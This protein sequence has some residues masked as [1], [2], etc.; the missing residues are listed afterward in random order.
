MHDG[1]WRVQALKRETR[2]RQLKMM[3]RQ[4]DYLETRNRRPVAWGR[5]M[6]AAGTEP[7]SRSKSDIEALNEFV[8]SLPLALLPVDTASLRVRLGN[9]F[10]CKAV[11][12]GSVIYAPGR[13]VGKYIYVI[14][15]GTVAL[16]GMPRAS[17]RSSKS[18]MEM[19][20]DKML[21]GDASERGESEG[22]IHKIGAGSIFGVAGRPAI[23]GA[24][25][26]HTNVQLV[27]F[28]RKHLTATVQAV[29]QEIGRCALATP[30]NAAL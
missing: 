28:E 21:Y 16:T 1:A 24:A 8:G 27:A 11:R 4:R 9:Q 6:R 3:E 18:E 26:A 2:A 12:K 20:A 13:N 5:L 14:H 10:E 29:Y 22:A 15:S 30:R 25:M 7:G 23:D 17:S 19:E